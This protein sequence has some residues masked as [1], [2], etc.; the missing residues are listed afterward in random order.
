MPIPT[1]TEMFSVVLEVMQDG[2]TRAIKEIKQTVKDHLTLTQEECNQKTDS[3]VPVHESR[4]GWSI[5][6]LNRAG[7]LTRV[8]RGVYRINDAGRALLTEDLDPTSFYHRLVQIIADT[9]PWN[10]GSSQNKEK[11]KASPATDNPPKSPREQVEDIVAEMNESLGNELLSLIL[12]RSPVFFEQIV[13]DLLERMGYGK[14]KVTQYSGD[15]GIDGL[16]TTDELGFRPIYTQAKRYA[17]ENKVG[18]SV[19][20]SFVGALN[21]AQNGVFIT[22][23]SFTKDAIEYAEG[24]PGATI[25]LIDGKRLT[26]LMT[27]YNL[28]VATETTVEIKRVDIDYFGDE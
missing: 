10:A 4:T 24:Y 5:T 1:Q 23:S 20:Q 3:G 14:G 17:P 19:V 25:A 13:I 18:R 6:Y 15:G 16:V 8:S 26:E 12:E 9:N 27:K 21:G 7:M 28:G 2:K 11:A 22:T